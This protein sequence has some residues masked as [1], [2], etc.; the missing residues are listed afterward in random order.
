MITVRGLLLMGT[1]DLPAK[2]EF[3]NFIQFNGNYGCPACFSKGENVPTE[4][5][6]SVH[7]YPY[8]AEPEMRTSEVCVEYG[9]IASPERP[10]MGIRGP[11]AFSKIMPDFM[12]GLAIDKMHCI[13]GGV[14]KKL[15][16]LLFDVKYRFRPFSLYHVIDVINTRLINIKPPKFVHRMPRSIQDLTHWKASELKLWFFYY[17]IPVFHGVMRQDFFEHY[18][19]L[20]VSISLLNGNFI[21]TEMR[22]I[23]HD[24]LHK[25]VKEFELKYGL[26][27]C[28]IN[29]HQLLHLAV[30][31]K[32]HGPLWAHS[33]FEYENLN[34]QFL[35][36]VHG[37]WHLDT[38]I[39]KSHAQFIKMRKFIERL[40]EG[41]LRD[42]CLHQKRQVKL[43]ER[44]I[45]HCY[46]VGYYKNMTD[47]MSDRI[48]NALQNSHLAQFTFIWQY[49]RLLKDQQLY[50]AELYPKDLQT[51]SYI[52][53][54]LDN[55]KRELGSVHCFLKIVIRCECRQI[56]CQ[57]QGHH[58][59]VIKQ[60]EAYDS[61]VAE[62]NQYTRPT[63]HFL[64]KCRITDNLLAI[65]I[66]Q[67]ENV[68]VRM[69][70]DGELYIAIPVNNKERE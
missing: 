11:N 63:G 44:I 4:N 26:E 27:F 65:N 9:N 43:I 2:A 67:I 53:E 55:G 32:I 37:T 14:V 56:V 31:V 17:S 12:K 59:A 35:K 50:V 49:L 62:G 54:Y 15:L 70:I 52:I 19:L 13:E 68:C 20:V 38:Q 25:F 45:P 8:E 64:N 22:E 7:V 57:C 3:L 46:S 28:T 34:G 33:C 5:E 47:D 48:R 10:V 40:P 1:C 6:G 58:V 42:F 18:L 21:N 36:L 30:S 39:V 61:F 66:T 24:M 41:P 23:A 29:I 60:L 51:E 16:T 69:V